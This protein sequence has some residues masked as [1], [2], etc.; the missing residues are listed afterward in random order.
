MC[1]A[2]LVERVRNLRAYAQVS[3][4]GQNKS[5]SR[6]TGCLSGTLQRQFYRRGSTLAAHVQEA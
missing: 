1:D 4:S 6:S 5:L 3:K 2:D